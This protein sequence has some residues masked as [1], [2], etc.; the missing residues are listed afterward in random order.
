MGNETLTIGSRWVDAMGN[1]FTLVTVN[2][3]VATFERR[4][5]D[6]GT[7]GFCKPYDVVERHPIPLEW[8]LDGSQFKPVGT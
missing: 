2:K 4:Y 3:H 7:P 5:T 1:V 6:P 8:A